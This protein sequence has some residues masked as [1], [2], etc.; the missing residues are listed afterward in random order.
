MVRERICSGLEHLGIV[1][2]ERLNGI[3]PNDDV[4]RI[5]KEDGAVEILIV[6]TD[7]EFE[8]ARKTLKIFEEFEG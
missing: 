5:G 6:K 1:L 3:S 4:S 2:D 8:I 7:E